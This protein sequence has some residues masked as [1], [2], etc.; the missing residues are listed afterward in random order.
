VDEALEAERLAKKETQASTGSSEGTA[1]RA[2]ICESV[3]KSKGDNGF[4][5]PTKV[6]EPFESV[7][8]NST[9]YYTNLNP[10]E[11]ER[12]LKTY[13]ESD[14]IATD[15]LKLNSKKYKMKFQT[16]QDKTRGPLDVEIKI[17]ENIDE[18]TQND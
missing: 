8:L 18:E 11:F 2:K 10:D 7:F 6:L 13:L 5:A 14:E 9:S 16:V 12:L 4:V 3:Y 17:F 1:Y 15:S